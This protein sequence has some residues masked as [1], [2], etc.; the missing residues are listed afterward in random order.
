MKIVI[1][2][3]A[4][5]PQVNGVVT[6]LSKTADT[7]RA[8]GH[9]VLMI[10]PEG[11]RSFPCPSYPEIR[12]AFF[13]GRRIARE[14]DAFRPDCIHIATEGPLGLATRRF[15]KRR[16]LA[17]TTSYHTQFPEYVRARVPLPI[18]WT[19]ALL[20]RFHRRASW[21]MVATPSMQT[22]LRDRGFDNIVTWTRGVDTSLF[23]P[24]PRHRYDLPAPIQVY[25][26]RVAVEKNLAAWL[27]V[28]MPGSK[29]VIGDGP[30][31]DKLRAEFPDAH[32]LGYKFG[33]ELAALLAG[34]DVFVFPS[35]TDTFGLVM[36]EG[37]ATGLPVAAF[38]VT[39]PIDVVQQG[40]TGI[41]DN[42]LA[43][44]CA[45][46]IKLD[47]QACRAFAES[48]GWSHS[49]G[50]FSGNLVNARTGESLLPVA[51]T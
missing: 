27:S 23:T 37:M 50:Q 35:L 29:V 11:R 47:R 26:G 49:V 12:L 48:R 22:L 1:A 10:T 33:D 31:L 6:T 4:W 51:T 5:K 46:A 40:V 44:A 9:D 43:S 17:F 30:D 28:N 32:F 38:P 34:G 25:A 18:A 14:I 42:D 19:Y 36:L 3:D 39:G 13:Q 41:L 16:G 2:T 15:C 20:R 45:E 24:E 8:A 7:L 21:T